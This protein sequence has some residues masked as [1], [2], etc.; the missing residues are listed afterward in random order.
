MFVV[1]WRHLQLQ[2]LV[3]VSYC[4][5]RPHFK[6]KIVEQPGMMGSMLLRYLNC[7]HCGNATQGSI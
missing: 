6:I 1:S 4:N 5:G 7:G 3:V 2:C